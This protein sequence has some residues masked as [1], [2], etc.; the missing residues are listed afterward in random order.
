MNLVHVKK[1]DVLFYKDSYDM[2]NWYIKKIR[3][4]N[5]DITSVYFKYKGEQYFFKY[6]RW[7]KA[8]KF[9]KINKDNNSDL[10]EI[11]KDFD[12]KDCDQDVMN[13]IILV[14]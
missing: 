1:I 14:K 8:G 2:F 11:C 7:T 9:S 13:I 6:A 5:K 10:Y 12:Y 4:K 3:P